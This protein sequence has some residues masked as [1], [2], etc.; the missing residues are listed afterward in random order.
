MDIHQSSIKDFILPKYKSLY[1]VDYYEGLQSLFLSREEINF[2]NFLANPR[3]RTHNEIIW[4]TECFSKKPTLLSNL[5]GFEKDKY[6]YLLNICIHAVK[7]LVNNLKNE[8]G[9]KDI[10]ELLSKSIIIINENYVYCGDDKI[11]I[12][13]WGIIPRIQEPINYQIYKDGAFIRN[14]DIKH[15]IPP[16]ANTTKQFIYK[17]TDNDFCAFNNNS[18]T[19]TST[20]SHDDKEVNIYE[21]QT[22]TS[23]EIKSINLKKEERQTSAK[24][25]IKDNIS[26]NF[27]IDKKVVSKVDNETMHTNV[28]EYNWKILYKEFFKGLKFLLKKLLLLFILITCFL[29][30]MALLKDCQG[31][32]HKINPFYS[33]LPE[34]TVVLPIENDHIGKS[35]D[36]MNLIATDRLNIIIDQ[37]HDEAILNWAK[38][39]K[40]IYDKREYKIIYYNR[41]LNH[42]Q[43]KVPDNE[44]EN[45]KLRLPSEISQIKFDV[46]DEIIQSGGIIISDPMINDPY[47]AWYFEPINANDAWN[48]TLGNEDIIIAVIDNGFDATHPE[49]I[50][51]VYNTYNILS[52]NSYIRPIITK[53]G[54]DAHGTHVAATAAGNYNNGSGLLGIAPKCKLMLIQE[55]I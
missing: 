50:G 47:K 11:V 40:K 42:L 21:T 12:V 49:L 5:T 36:G 20:Q 28:E 18:S 22:I 1:I 6:S 24:K 55:D 9:G 45:I 10:G 53:D 33:P 16:T 4:S 14:W 23:R 17:V 3:V 30:V 8:E 25:D 2:K 29:L 44:R 46:F 39:F 26:K 34:N 32:V 41:E 7:D 38:A 15:N 37:Q 51:R 35:S 31:P 48:I 27:N 19:S 43:I 13:N 52:K 54:V